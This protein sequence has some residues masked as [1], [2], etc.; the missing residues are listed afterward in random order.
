MVTQ[1]LY[2]CFIA[3]INFFYHELDNFNSTLS[4]AL[5]LVELEA[6]KT[7]GKWGSYLFL[8]VVEFRI[9]FRGNFERV[10]GVHPTSSFRVEFKIEGEGE[11]NKLI[12]NLFSHNSIFEGRNTS[13]HFVH[14]VFHVSLFLHMYVCVCVCVE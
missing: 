13:P 8:E 11:E 12:S 10:L 4:L 14:V 9:L 1:K 7:L 2:F 3:K 6:S 5:G